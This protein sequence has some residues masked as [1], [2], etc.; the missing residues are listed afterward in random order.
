MI[1]IGLTPTQHKVL[2]RLLDELDDHYGN[3][4]CNDLD[5]EVIA[6]F[7]PDDIK[8]LLE[9]LKA[10]NPERFTWPE[11]SETYEWPVMDSEVLAWVKAAINNGITGVKGVLV[12][13]T[14]TNP[15]CR[16]GDV[17]VQG[18]PQ[19]LPQTEVLGTN[20]GLQKAIA[21]IQQEAV[22]AYK[23]SAWHTMPTGWGP[24]K[25]FVES[26][27]KVGDI[28]MIKSKAGVIGGKVAG[29]FKNAITLDSS[30]AFGHVISVDYDH[31]LALNVL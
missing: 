9:W 13:A 16:G 14:P 6:M 18:L 1:T 25:V 29:L 31:V 27:V 11:S 19:T 10:A 17:V 15:D 28:V 2:N 8:S 12:E 22:E 4:G 23:K 21:G 26:R 24:P 30:G 3:A 5:Q 20:V 7:S